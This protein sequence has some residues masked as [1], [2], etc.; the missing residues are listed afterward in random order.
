MGQE[1]YSFRNK[2]AAPLVLEDPKTGKQGVNPIAVGEPL[3]WYASKVTW[4][5][6]IG[7]L[8]GIAGLI[9]IS[10]PNEDANHLAESITKA[11]PALMA[12]YG[13]LTVIFRRMAK[14]P[15]AGSA[16]DPTRPSA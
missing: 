15:I 6:L 11:A 8:V 14:K 7:F 2:S 1:P 12:V 16:A 9:G 3:P 10:V 4:V 5:G 13:I